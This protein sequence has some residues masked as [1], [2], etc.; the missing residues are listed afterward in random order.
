MNRT[1]SGVHMSVRLRIEA[2][3]FLVFVLMVLGMSVASLAVERRHLIETET[4]HA[5]ALLEHLAA[6]PEMHENLAQAAAMLE[7]LRPYL[8]EVGGEIELRPAAGAGD[9]SLASQALQFRDGSFDLA[10]VLEPEHIRR[11]MVRG[12]VTHAFGGIIALLFLV[13]GTEWILRTRLENPINRISRQVRHIRSGGGW[14]VPPAGVDT[15]LEELTRELAELGPVLDRQVSEV[16]ETERRVAVALTLIRMHSRTRPL[17]DKLE[18]TTRAIRLDEAS[19]REA[20]T[21]LRTIM[22]DIAELSDALSPSDLLWE[23]C[24][25][26]AQPRRHDDTDPSSA[27]RDVVAEPS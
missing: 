15:E 5:E 18:A 4:V 27:S 16:V 2:W 23:S 3:M 1:A 9:T 22:S 13:V 26:V 25:G 19:S 7:S 24:L 10:Y 12:A 14:L 21:N 6:M 17:L 11:K 20:R 8:R